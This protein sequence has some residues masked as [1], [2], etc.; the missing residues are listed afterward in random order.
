MTTVYH[1]RN[2]RSMRVLWLLEELGVRAEIKSLPFPPSKLQP[3]YLS[4][5]PTGTVPTLVDGS[6]RLTESMAICEYLA[7][8]YKSSLLVAPGDAARTDFVQWLWYGESTLMTPLSRIAT[9]SR[10]Q[11]KGADI[12]A[13]IEDA[14]NNAGVRLKALENR[15]DGRDF[16]IAGRLTLADI[17]AGY[18]LH[19]VGLFGIDHM[20]GPRSTAYRERLRSR[21]AYQRAIA[22]P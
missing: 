7:T 20:L 10:L 17:S 14:R 13:V 18:P 3:D 8:K 12:D 2:T 21:P 22:V 9:V 5:N 6:V 16:L 19:L 4:V 11:R 15:L 1:A